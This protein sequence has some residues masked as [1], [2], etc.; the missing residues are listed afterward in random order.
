MQIIHTENFKKN[1]E[2]NNTC[3]DTWNT[4]IQEKRRQRDWEHSGNRYIRNTEMLYIGV[5][6]QKTLRGKANDR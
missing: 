3:R 2:I 6:V 4:R 1:M 5:P